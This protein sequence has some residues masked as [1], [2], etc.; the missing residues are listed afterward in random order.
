MPTKEAEGADQRLQKDG[1]GFNA[2][3]SAI[4]CFIT[5]WNSSAYGVNEDVVVVVGKDAL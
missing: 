1:R 2:A 3:S 4:S 5:R